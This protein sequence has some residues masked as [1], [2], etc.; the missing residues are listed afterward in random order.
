MVVSGLPLCTV[1]PVTVPQTVTFSPTCFVASEGLMVCAC[2]PTKATARQ[3]VRRSFIFY[4]KDSGPAHTRKPGVAKRFGKR[5][6]SRKNNSVFF[7]NKA[8]AVRSNGYFAY[9]VAGAT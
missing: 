8:Y 6:R 1:V 9:P 3:R 2:S 5:M 7:G 4:F